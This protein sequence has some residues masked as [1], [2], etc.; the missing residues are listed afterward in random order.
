MIITAL[1]IVPESPRYLVARGRSD[2]A[3]VILADLHANGK[4]DDELVLNSLAEI[5][6]AL[7]LGKSCS[8]SS[9][10]RQR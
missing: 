4:M 2:E 3:H 6:G 1:F 7:T 9:S 10:R 5:K 8:F